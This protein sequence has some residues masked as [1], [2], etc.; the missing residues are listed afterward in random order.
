[1][2]R[3][4]QPLA[5]VNRAH[6]RSLHSG[7]ILSCNIHSCPQRCH[8]LHDHS[9]MP[10]NHVKESQ[11]PEG[12][13]QRW[14]CHETDPPSCRKCERE[15]RERERRK[16]E[17]FRLQQQE[18][19]RQREHA[20][21]MAR[22]DEKISLEMQKVKDTQ[23]QRQR[24]LAIQQKK[25]DLKDA[26]ARAT[27]MLST[28]L[29]LQDPPDTK[30]HTEKPASAPQPDA[31]QT[32]SQAKAN[33]AESRPPSPQQISASEKEWQR[34]KEVENAQNEAIDSIMDMTGLEDVKSQV[35]R[36][37][38]RIDVS[39]RQ[40]TDL[41]DERFNVVFLGNP[42][43]GIYLHPGGVLLWLIV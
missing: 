6:C 19:E 41:K 31:S 4:L 18:D 35:L 42:G 38:A 5:N 24:E 40:N 22:L 21:E 8:Q 12:H 37:K 25:K 32:A 28:S 27:R 13:V 1:M 7:T 17:A 20:K 3:N 15:I 36:I 34:Q 11:C 39:L 10:C 43:T 23:A 16:Q 9:K 26:A 30:P 14:R 2:V 29:P 33:P